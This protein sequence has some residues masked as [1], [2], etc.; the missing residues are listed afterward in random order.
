MWNIYWTE[1]YI[2]VKMAKSQN[3]MFKNAEKIL[4][5]KKYWHSIYPFIKILKYAKN[6]ILY[7]NTCICYRNKTT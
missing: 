1:Y 7:I 6:H 2:I 3:T 5:M 4:K